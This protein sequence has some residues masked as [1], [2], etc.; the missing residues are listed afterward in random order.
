MSRHLYQELN[1]SFEFVLTFQSHSLIG[2]E[3]EE[4]L[5]IVEV[6]IYLVCVVFVLDVGYWVCAKASGMHMNQEA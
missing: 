6:L 1:R 3:V 4:V 2:F 5:T